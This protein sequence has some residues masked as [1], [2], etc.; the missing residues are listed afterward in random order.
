MHNYF[1]KIF[2]PVFAASIALLFIAAGCDNKD[3][4]LRIAPPEITVDAKTLSASATIEASSVWMPSGNSDW[5][6]AYKDADDP[7]QLRISIAET[8]ESLSPRETEIRI[9]TGDAQEAVIKVFQQAL[10]ASIEV[11]PS[12]LQEFDGQGTRV[13]TLTVTL[14]NIDI[15]DLG[16]TNTTDW[17]SVTQGE[18]NESNILTVKAAHSDELKP[19]SDEIII[20]SA[21]EGFES[22]N[23]TISVTQKGVN[24]VLLYDMAMEL[25]VEVD[26]ETTEVEYTIAASHDWTVSVNNGGTP[27]ETSGSAQTDGEEFIVTIPKN[28]GTA[29]VSYSATFQCGGEEYIYTIIQSAP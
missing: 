29:A 3:K 13:Q 27:G 25:E 10:D 19:R 4:Y 2:N 14:K 24:L 6:N 16:F 18:G 28:T 8:N 12:E 1:K 5:L 7:T 26:S 22:L 15:D 17:L 23:K 9:T 11:T 20:G 21:K